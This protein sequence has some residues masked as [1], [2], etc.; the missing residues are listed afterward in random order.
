MTIDADRVDDRENAATPSPTSGPTQYVVRTGA[1]RSLSVMQ[2]SRPFRYGERVVVRTERGTEFGVILCE[3]TPAAI[4]H[5]EEPTSGR[6]LR[7]MSADDER[8]WQIQQDK[9]E[10]DVTFAARAAQ[11][12]GLEMKVVDVERLLGGE[13]IV[14]YFISEKRIDFRMLVRR[15]AEEFKT[16]IE[17]RQIG[18]RD[19]AKLLADFG[20]CGKPLC[21]NTHLTKMPP[22]SMRMAKLQKATLDPTKISG[23][24]GRLKC[25]LRYEFDTYEELQRE[26]PSVGSRIVTGDGPA[27]VLGQ[28]ILSQQLLVQTEDNRRILIPTSAV[29]AVTNKSGGRARSRTQHDDDENQ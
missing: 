3:A 1:V 18:V 6:V 14:F 28:E 22:V 23:R 8:A 17:M 21:C 27:T 25:C 9:T 16:R 15:L 13:R 12:L 2:A 11:E 29:L 7:G 20:D 10:D 26:M 5:L 4:V 19:E 24:C